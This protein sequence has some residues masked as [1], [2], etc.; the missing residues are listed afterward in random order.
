VLYTLSLA[1]VHDLHPEDFERRKLLVLTVLR[2][3]GAVKALDTAVGR[4]GPYWARRIVGAIPMSAINRVNKVLGPRFV[5][6]YGTKQGV[7]VLSKQVPL[8]IGAA[9]GA[10][11]N[12]V[13]GRLTIRSARA[14][15]GPAASSWAGEDHEDEAQL[16]PD[17]AD[18]T[19]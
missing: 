16:G 8:G 10:G 4:T 12:H 11:G 14:I 17:S 3:D 2:G 9:L 1:E 5:T 6:K 15:F 13:F 19:P 18:P 7:L